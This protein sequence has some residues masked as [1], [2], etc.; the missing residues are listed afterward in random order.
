MTINIS[1]PN[2]PNLRKLHH[3]D[4][5]IPFLKE[6]SN[7][8]I[9]LAKQHQQAPVPLLLKIS[10]DESF[11]TLELIVSNAVD[12]GFS[13]LLL[14]ILL[15]AVLVI[16]VTKIFETGGLSGNPIESKSLSIVKF[17]AKVTDHKFP[18]IG[19]GGISCL[20]SALRN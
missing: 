15:L 1:S 6:L 18:I 2:T 5:I 4:F 20:D 11:H 14:R 17:L 8:N 10:P 7:L 9:E 16:E 12:L 19:V 13:V 3:S